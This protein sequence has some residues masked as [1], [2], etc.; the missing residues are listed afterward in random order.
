MDR[1]E[2]LTENEIKELD[3]E[4]IKDTI[5]VLRNYIYITDPENAYQ[6]AELYELK[7]AQK[8]LRCPFFE[9]RVRGINDLK[10]IYYKVHNASFKTRQQIEAQSL[11]TTRWLTFD[12]YAAWLIQEKIVEYIF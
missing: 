1:L 5:E 4:I 12:K 8:Y 9:K 6:I 7:V 10:D 2:N 11:E 3:K